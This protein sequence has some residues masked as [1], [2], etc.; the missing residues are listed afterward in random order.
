MLT[1]SLLK[2]SVSFRNSRAWMTELK[3]LPLMK[4]RTHL[5][6]IFAELIFL[7]SQMASQLAQLQQLDTQVDAA[8]TAAAAATD[9]GN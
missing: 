5:L 3:P 7:N 6:F 1:S 9:A 2:V 8:F 4:L